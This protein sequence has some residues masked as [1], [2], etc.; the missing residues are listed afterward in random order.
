MPTNTALELATRELD[1]LIQLG[2][3]VVARAEN[4]EASIKGKELAEIMAWASR[5]GHI[6][7]SVAGEGS[8]YDE[9][10]ASARRD[11]SFSFI[12]AEIVY[13]CVKFRAL[14]KACVT[15]SAQV[16]SKT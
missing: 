10:F 3:T 13:T 14:S 7:R 6:I 11:E 2:D 16:F 9:A 1:D 12:I 8:L 5:A 4:S 15:L